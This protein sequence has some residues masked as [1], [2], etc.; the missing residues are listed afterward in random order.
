MTEFLWAGEDRLSDIV[1]LWQQGF[2]ADSEADIRDFWYALKGEARCLLLEEDDEAR[3]M[4]FVIPAKMNGRIVWY[5]YAAATARQWRGRGYFTAL[6]EELVSRAVAQN[7]S[8]L[9]LRPASQSLFT[10]YA[11]LGFVPLFYHEEVECEAEK[12]YTTNGEMQWKR[13][14]DGIAAER[15]RR[16]ALLGVSS[17]AWT[18]TVTAY[19]VSLLEDGGVLVSE[20][21]MAMYRR[22]GNGVEITELLC[23][24]EETNDVLHSLS[25]YLPCQITRVY[26][27]P[28]HPSDAQVY[29]MFRAI[30]TTVT[31]NEMWYMG[32]SLE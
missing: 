21:G 1:A 26:R 10:Y 7:V 11:R 27:P 4:A 15:Y 31:P 16:L 18:E 25:S 19:A 3:S 5:V 8:G 23:A 32:F 28:V 14:T 22:D 30:N 20:K 6:L 24:E 2:P 9:F 29:G 13:I 17:V 12:L